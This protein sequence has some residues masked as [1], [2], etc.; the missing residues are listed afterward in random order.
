MADAVLQSFVQKIRTATSR[1][2]GGSAAD[3]ELLARFAASRDEAAFAAL[4]A[5]YGCLVRNVCRNVLRDERDVEEATQATFLLLAHRANSLRQPGALAGWLHGVARRTALYTRRTA[6]RRRA[7]ER[8]ASGSRLVPP[9]DPS[10]EA[11]WRELQALLDEE[12][13]RL[14]DKLRAPFVLCCLEGHGYKDAARRLGW[15]PGTV[16]GRL[17]AARKLLRRRLA[18]RGVSL[19]AVL[20]GLAVVGNARADLSACFVTE[21]IAAAVR[22]VGARATVGGPGVRLAGEMLQGTLAGRV[23]AVVLLLLAFGVLSAGVG[24]VLLAQRVP[25]AGPEVV[26]LARLAPPPT[27]EAAPPSRLDRHGDALPDHAIARLGTKRFD[28]SFVTDRVVW[29]PDGKVLAT[30]GGNSMGRQLCLWDAATGREL[31]DLPA[32]EAVMAAAFSPDGKTLAATEP[33]GAVLWDVVTGKEVA[34]FEAR[35]CAWAVAFSPDGKTLAVADKNNV[36]QLWDIASGL[37]VGQVKGLEKEPVSL[38]FSPDGRTIAVATIQGTAGVWEVG[39]KEL[40]RHTLPRVKTRRAV[41]LA[42]APGGKVLAGITSEL[43]IRLWD[44]RDGTELRAFGDEAESPEPA[45]GPFAPATIAYSPDG[46]M[47]LAPGRGATLVLWDPA[48]GREVR[49]WHSGLMH[50]MSVQFAPDGRTVASGG[51]F[52]STVRLWDPA[53]GEERRPTPG[54]HGSVRSVEFTPDG[55]SLWSL[56]QDRSLIHW[57]LATA[58]GKWFFGGPVVGVKM[59]DQTACSSDARLVATGGYQ[60]GEIRLWDNAGHE[61]GTLGRHDG[62]IVRVLFSPDNKFL[63]TAGRGGGVRVWDVATRMETCR[64][65]GAPTDSE[66]T[67]AFSPDGRRLIA[68]GFRPN[69]PRISQPRVIDVPTGKELFHLDTDRTRNAAVFSPDGRLLA[70]TGN[71]DHPLVQIWDA[72]TG[73]ELGHWDVPGR[74]WPSLVFAPDGRYL[75]TGGAERDST[76]RLWEVATRQEVAC[77]R[78]HH[79]GIGALA[80]APDGRMLASGASDATVLVW[81]LTG[82]AIPGGNHPET[83]SSARLEECWAD[84]LSPEAAKAYRSIRTLAADPGRAVPFLAKRTQPARPVDAALLARLVGALDAATFREREKAE[85]E[86]TESGLAAAEPALKKLRDGS[87]PAEA[88]RRAG[89]LLERLGAERLRL[90]RALAALEYCGTS[91]ARR[92]LEVL[93][94]SSL[95]GL[96]ASEARAALTRLRQLAD[97]P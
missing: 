47:L 57:D 62:G 79:S 30:T 12:L 87:G 17:D 45:V 21:T 32:E 59:G 39:G 58:V 96:Q 9:P 26:A 16:S 3:E 65:E 77:Y 76:V 23:R 82:Y 24:A 70:T 19:S 97:R 78:G 86:L 67:L 85:A 64:L 74:Y 53:T 92:A 1:S 91:E 37:V 51:N 61:L 35:S 27:A 6:A 52:G 89:S 50:V 31:H 54:H 36:V 83:L 95:E 88:K 93:A 46:K 49:R 75:A 11:S 33:R 20:C 7:V 90:R 44:P 5:R 94:N 81:D 10:V 14:P 68:C 72:A 69:G 41:A 63:A 73:Q 28:H 40:W 48:T 4:V 29:S 18:R 42:F 34:R 25:A 38:A 8:G 13:Q 84:L 56:G 71:F 43:T 66:G 15:K 80:F 2:P 55:K 60:D 22:F